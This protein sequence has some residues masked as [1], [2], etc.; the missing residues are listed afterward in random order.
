MTA[1][2]GPPGREREGGLPARGTRPEHARTSPQP[3]AAVTK[4][5]LNDG[6][7]IRALLALSDERDQWMRWLLSAGRAAYREGYDDGFRD[8]GE[9][10]FA[11]RRAWPPIIITGEM[12][13]ELERR[14]WGP[15]GREHAGDPRPGDY[16]GRREGAA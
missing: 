2:H 7:D 11:R 10:L 1:R 12:R 6:A 15:G 8:G 13:A 4:F 16:P 5:S 3:S 9:E 14:R